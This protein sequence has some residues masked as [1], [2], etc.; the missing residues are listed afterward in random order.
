MTWYKLVEYG[1]SAA[2]DI[3]VTSLGEGLH[4]WKKNPVAAI[5]KM[6]ITLIC[7][8]E[9]HNHLFHVIDNSGATDKAAC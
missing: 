8:K 4:A 9:F 7:L 5:V 3:Y 2:A 6:S 1:H